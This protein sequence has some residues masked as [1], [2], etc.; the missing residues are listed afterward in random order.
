MFDLVIRNGTVIAGSGRPR[1]RADVRVRD[2]RIAS[3]GRIGDKGAEEVDAEGK[4][5]T[6]GFVEVHTHMDAQVFWD[7]LGTCSSWHGVTSAVMGN[8]GFTLAP[9]AEVDK[10]LVM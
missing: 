9:C 2:G 10:N 1:Y 7:T 6:P 4:F 8:C 3:I 5:V